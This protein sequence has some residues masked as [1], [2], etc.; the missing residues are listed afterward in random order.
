MLAAA[1]L[2]VA[3]LAGCTEDGDGAVRTHDPGG[4]ESSAA[5]A[6]G[7]DQAVASGG[8]VVLVA[9]G[10][11]GNELVGIDP[12]SGEQ[13]WSVGLPFDGPVA[14]PSVLGISAQAV[15][16]AAV[17][18]R[19]STSEDYGRQC[20]PGGV[21]VAI[22]DP[23]ADVWTEAVEAIAPGD[24]TIVPRLVGATADEVVVAA[25]PH[26]ATMSTADQS[27]RRLPDAPIDPSGTICLVDDTVLVVEQRYG[28]PVG[29]PQ[30]GSSVVTEEATYVP[31]DSA[32]L[33]LGQ[34]EW[35]STGGP[36]A[37]YDSTETFAV[38]CSPDGVAVAPTERPLDEEN[39][40]YAPYQ[41]THSNVKYDYVWALDQ[42]INK[43]NQQ[44]SP[45]AV[46]DHSYYASNF[47]KLY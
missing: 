10:D 1:L 18:C 24:A 33:D 15:A 7:S 11:P 46:S 32:A 21:A 27:V 5:A 36:D 26:L 37:T 4:A 29:P 20:E 41:P 34:P 19:T 30:P 8:E 40:E 22:Y 42:G 23:S 6:G 38:A 14:F 47:Q 16:V 45:L 25:G 9:S 12:E 2:V 13:R 39:D 43:L 31:V 44:I 28:P 17:P 3:L 35:R